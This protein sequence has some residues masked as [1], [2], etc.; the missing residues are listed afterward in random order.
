M[1]ASATVDPLNREVGNGNRARQLQVDRDPALGEQIEGEAGIRHDA[2][3]I[4]AGAPQEPQELHVTEQPGTRPRPLRSRDESERP[5]LSRFAIEASAP[6]DLDHR[7]EGVEGISHEPP[8]RAGSPAMIPAD[9]VDRIRVRPQINQRGSLLVDFRECP[10]IPFT[11]MA[12]PEPSARVT[13]DPGT[14]RFALKLLE[15]TA[16]HRRRCRSV[17]AKNARKRGQPRRR[18]G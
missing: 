12:G 6:R 18:D 10:R 7:R 3:R 14:E 5:R 11:A 9:P 1:S 16:G 4:G 2:R 13:A 8:A 17:I 15:F